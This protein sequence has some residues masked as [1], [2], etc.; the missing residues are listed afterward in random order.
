M[1]TSNQLIKGCRILK[2]LRKCKLLPLDGSPFKKGTC[3]K[4]RI[5]KPRK[6]N[7]ALRK[8]VRVK[9][10]NKKIISAYIP[11]QGHNLQ[12]HSVVLIKGGRTRDLPGLHYKLI[13][14]KY[15]FN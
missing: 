13:R 4:L 11:G 10:S 1:S 5:V 6:P 15:D 14:G 7:S 3:I 12:P 9:L 8:M 2:I